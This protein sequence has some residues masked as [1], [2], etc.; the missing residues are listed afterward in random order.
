MN[1]GAQQR[2]I[3]GH[4]YQMPKISGQSVISGQFQDS[5]EIAGISGIS[6]RL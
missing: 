4:S 6:G 3:S 2:K 1:A 5:F